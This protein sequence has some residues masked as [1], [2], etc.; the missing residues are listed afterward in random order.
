MIRVLHVTNAY[1]YDATPEY[2]VFV[3]EQIDSLP[4]SEVSSQLVFINGRAFGK[5]A[6]WESL[7]NIRSLAKQCDVI[8][9]HHLYSA[10]CVLLSQSGRPVV[11]SFLN[12]WLH[13][14]KGARLRFFSR[15]LCEIGVRF[16]DKVIFKSPIPQGLVGSGKVINLPNGVD[17]AFFDVVDRNVAKARLGLDS[18]KNYLLFVSSK[19]KLRAQKRYDLFAKVVER[20]SC[21]RPDLNVEEF[22][23]VGQT[24]DVVPTI[25]NAMS[26]HV[27]TSDFEGSPNSVKE[28]LSCG[29]PVVSRDVG[30]VAD[31]LRD[32]PFTAVVATDDV[33]EI[34]SLVILI[35]DAQVDRRA[36]RAGF[37]SHGIT[38]EAVASRLVS[39][40][41]EVKNNANA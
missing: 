14:V 31:M 7:K 8:H 16:V 33:S 19:N 10:L 11:L 38:R 41:R 40:Y 15:W 22:V 17:S 13:E 25:F 36:L 9:C 20:I 5:R 24:R 35:L 21:L 30:N 26:V 6:Y 32:V 12:D 1:P 34:A 37:L 18:D 2:G 28:A 27:L 23:M 3:K 4:A 29:V 39:L